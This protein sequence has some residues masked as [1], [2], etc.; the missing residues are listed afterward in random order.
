ME[1]RNLENESL[2]SAAVLL[3]ALNEDNAGKVLKHLSE[4]DIYKEVLSK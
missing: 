4:S 3:L 2:E 1:L